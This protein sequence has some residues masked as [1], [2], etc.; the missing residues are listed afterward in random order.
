MDLNTRTELDCRTAELK[1]AHIPL[2]CTKC[3]R[4]STMQLLYESTSFPLASMA[5]CYEL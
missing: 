4:Q 3:D 2:E 1:G 5:C